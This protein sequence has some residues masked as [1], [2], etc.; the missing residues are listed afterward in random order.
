M[1]TLEIPNDM[2]ATHHVAFKLFKH[3][4]WNTIFIV[5][6][7]E[8]LVKLYEIVESN[9]E[10]ISKN[11]I[12]RSNGRDILLLNDSCI[13]FATYESSLSYLTG[14]SFDDIF[15]FGSQSTIEIDFTIATS[16]KNINGIFYKV[17]DPAKVTFERI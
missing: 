11:S 4:H 2:I 3:T 12:V 10:C 8:Y 9:L 16:F 17:Y 6:N 14:A 13:M 7:Y 1:R 5:P 15:Y